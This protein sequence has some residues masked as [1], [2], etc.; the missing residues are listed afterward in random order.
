[1]DNKELGAICFASIKLISIKHGWDMFT[2]DILQ[3]AMLREAKPKIPSTVTSLEIYEALVPYF[4]NRAKE[5]DKC[6]S[7]FI[8][9]SLEELS[10]S[11]FGRIASVHA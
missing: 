10:R 5:D 6:V 8:G 3:S 9:M 2:A 7:S 1:M 11:V 4:A